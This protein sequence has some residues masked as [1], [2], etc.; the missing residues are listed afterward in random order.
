MNIEAEKE[1]DE[2]ER[3]SISKAQLAALNEIYGLSEK[4]FYLIVTG[5][6]KTPS[7][8]YYL[9]GTTEQFDALASDL[10]DEI[11]NE[12]SPK[13]RLKHLRTLYNKI[14]PDDLDY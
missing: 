10:S 6:R 11:Y 8:H 3:V 7:G 12:L 14:N 5:E 9:E 13:T 2:L 1:K 4:A